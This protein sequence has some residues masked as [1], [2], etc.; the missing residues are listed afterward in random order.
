MDK[1]KEKVVFI[2]GGGTG[3]HIYPALAIAKEIRVL[4]LATIF[5]S[6]PR[7]IRDIAK[8]KNIPIF[9]PH[10]LEFMRNMGMSIIWIC[11]TSVGRFPES[12][13]KRQD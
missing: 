8:E 3:G 9:L 6:F 13:G 7:M 11:Q 2:T 1:N 12:T 4:P 5:H 10:T